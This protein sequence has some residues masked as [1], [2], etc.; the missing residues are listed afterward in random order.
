MRFGVLRPAELDLTP[1][2]LGSLI[3]LLFPPNTLL[4][5]GLYYWIWWD[6]FMSNLPCVLTFELGGLLVPSLLLPLCSSELPDGL[7]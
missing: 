2:C 6:E 7:V 4:L 5:S 3:V 1:S